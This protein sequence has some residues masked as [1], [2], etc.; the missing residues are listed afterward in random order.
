M[1]A[2]SV[3]EQ[4]MHV[5]SDS[6]N[7]NRTAANAAALYSLASPA[8]LG[9]MLRVMRRRWMAT[10]LETLNHS[11]E[12]ACSLASSIESMLAMISRA[13]GVTF[14]PVSD[15]AS[16]RARSRARSCSPSTFDEAIDSVRRRSRAR[17][18]SAGYAFAFSAAI[19]DSAFETAP[20]VSASSARSRFESLSGMNARYRHAR[21]CLGGASRAG[22]YC[23]VRSFQVPGNPNSA[24]YVSSVYFINRTKAGLEVRP[25]PAGPSWDR[26]F[27]ARRKL[28]AL[29]QFAPFGRSRPQA[30]APSGSCALRQCALSGS[31]AL[32][33]LRP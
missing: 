10:M 5:N 7:V 22:L 23:Q 17:G 13:V 3:F 11:P 20:A 29:R 27:P 15:L 8:T 33:Q 6:I 28:L 4:P 32:R 26:R 9:V 18:A 21:R 30:V 19:A 24:W 12:E 16:A 25:I 14:S 31:C 2:G 1:G